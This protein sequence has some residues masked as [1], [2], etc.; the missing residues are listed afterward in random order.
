M[1]LFHVYLNWFKRNFL[2]KCVSQPKIAKKNP[3]KTPNLAFKIIQGHYIQ[4]ISR[5][6]VRL[7]ISD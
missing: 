1:Q 2:F 4:R 5:A 7:P 3:L 6:S